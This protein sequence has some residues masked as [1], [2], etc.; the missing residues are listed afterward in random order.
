MLEKVNSILPCTEVK[1]DRASKI[2]EGLKSQYKRYVIAMIGALKHMDEMPNELSHNTLA[3]EE[4][5]LHFNS[6][7]STFFLVA[8]WFYNLMLQF[9]K[10]GVLPSKKTSP[11]NSP[12]PE[13]NY[14]GLY[15]YP[16]EENGIK[17]V[18]LKVKVSYG[19]KE[20]IR[21]E[22]AVLVTG[23]RIDWNNPQ[24]WITFPVNDVRV[25]DEKPKSTGFKLSDTAIFKKWK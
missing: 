4:R 1:Q 25:I 5:E 17:Y 11:S 10:E 15:E 23:I 6:D 22:G 19:N 13:S 18:K 12:R 20:L 24:K 8:H 2:I 9:E 7:Y 14:D 21:K 16:F 3:A